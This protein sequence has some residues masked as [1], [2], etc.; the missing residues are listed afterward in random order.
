MIIRAHEC[1]KGGIQRFANQK[2][3]TVFSATNYCNV[4]QNKGAM[5]LVKTSLEIIT[6]A[7]SPFSDNSQRWRE[8]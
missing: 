3:I 1:V 6:K 4:H 7:I 2:L 5:L 8:K